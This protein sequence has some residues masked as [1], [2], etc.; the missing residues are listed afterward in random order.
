MEMNLAAASAHGAIQTTIERLARII[1][2][3]GFRS[4]YL[5]L[6]TTLYSL[7]VESQVVSTSLAR[8]VEFLADEGK[9]TLSIAIQTNATLHQTLSQTLSGCEAIYARLDHELIDISAK[10][11]G[12]DSR[13]GD[14]TRQ[15]E[16]YLR[17]KTLEDAL[18][19][20]RGHQTALN[21]FLHMY[22]GFLCNNLACTD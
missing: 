15:A 22:V 7:H 11:E 2:V 14:P 5:V 1:D 9:Q 4:R 13:Q 8:L 10:V 19:K 20:I 21:L 16:L 17:C 18:S 12:S 3:E 6:A